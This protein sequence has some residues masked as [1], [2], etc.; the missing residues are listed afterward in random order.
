LLVN[1][2]RQTGK[3]WLLRDFAER[4]YENSV[5]VTLDLNSRVAAYFEDDLTP[6]RLI[7]LLEAEFQQRILPGRTLLVLDEIQAS[8]RA[9][10]SLKYFAEQAPEFHVAAAGSLLGV[11]VNREKFSF[12]VGQVHTL[13]LF[14]LDFEEFLWACGDEVMASEI[15][16]AHA[17]WS[18]L[19]EALHLKGIDRYREYLAVGGMPACVAAHISGASLIEIP[20]IQ[21]E[22]QR[23]YVADMAKYASAAD[24]VRIRACYNSLPAQLAKDNHKFQY[25]V[26]R[27]GGSAALFGSAIEWLTLAGVALKCRRLDAGSVPLA[28]HEDLS[29]FKLYAGDTG[30][31]SCSAGLRIADVLT[32]APHA[33]QSALAENFVAQQLAPRHRNLFYWTSG[34]EAEVDFVVDSEAGPAAI[35]VKSSDNARSRSLTLFKRRYEPALAVRL[36][37]KN[38]G[39]GETRSVPL[40]ATHLL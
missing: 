21:A 28:G 15:A 23:N 29:S 20:E 33:F 32:G 4:H 14:P 27:R 37:T 40:Y 22:I 36:S 3:T 17:A 24:A 7:R 11:A 16:A 34:N 12:P 6:T 13:D 9:L 26:V 19:P 10:T 38:Y 30:L 31:L 5:H 1:G 25:K 2:A 18:P 39:H 8:E 35:E